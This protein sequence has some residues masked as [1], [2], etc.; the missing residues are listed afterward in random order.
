MGAEPTDALAAFMVDCRRLTRA[1]GVVSE[2]L[3]ASVPILKSGEDALQHMAA[4]TAG[5]VEL[6]ERLAAAE[7]EILRIGLPGEPLA[8][9]PPPSA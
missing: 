3:A 4:I 8:P 7:S 9:P 1:L 2:G 6:E 5:R